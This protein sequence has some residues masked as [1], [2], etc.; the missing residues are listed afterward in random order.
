[1]KN[2]KQEGI[3]FCIG[4]WKPNTREGGHYV[5]TDAWF[6]KRTAFINSFPHYKKKYGYVAIRVVYGTFKDNFG[7]MTLFDNDGCYDTIKEAKEVF[8]DFIDKDL[9]DYMTS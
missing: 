3:R 5:R 1:M 2:N 4:E 6:Q 8:L 7:N 9:I